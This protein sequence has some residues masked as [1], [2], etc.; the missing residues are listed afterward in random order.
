[1]STQPPTGSQNNDNL[2][3]LFNARPA[4]GDSGGNMGTGTPYTPPPMQPNNKPRQ[5]P[6][7]YIVL[8]LILGVICI[9]GGC[10]LLGGGTL[11]AGINAV[12]NDPTV[13]AA[14]AT[15]QVAF[16][17]G[18]AI[19]EVPSKLPSDANDQGTLSAG[20][21]QTGQLSTME[22]Q[23]WKY[24]THAGEK[25]KVTVSA[26]A[27]DVALTLGIYNSSGDNVAKSAAPN[28]KQTLSYT[29]PSDGTISVLVG[30]FGNSG[31]YTIQVTS[32]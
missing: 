18:V 25:I 27:G 9:C 14:L 4:S 15:G 21:Q 28:L 12:A 13:K 3:D 7:L 2:D 8:G 32:G 26:T 23:V 17:T 5:N 10:L 20:Q 31:N 19:M 22:R 1:M 24:Q 29:V 16:G 30:G 6:I 11:F